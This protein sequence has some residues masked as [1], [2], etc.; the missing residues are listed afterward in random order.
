MTEDTDRVDLDALDVGEDEEEN[1]QPR[2]GEWFWNEES[3][4]EVAAESAEAGSSATDDEAGETGEVTTPGT[5]DTGATDESS[6]SDATANDDGRAR[7]PHVPRENKNQPVGIPVAEGGAGGAS[8]RAAAERE[9]DAEE[10][11]DGAPAEDG[12][13]RGGTVGTGDSGSPASEMTMAFSYD[14]M[15]RFASPVLVMAN[16]EEWTDWIG[17]VG[18]VDAY[19][20]NKYVREEGLDID[21]FNGAGD[22]PA[23]R[24]A[25]ITTNPNSMFAAE[26]TVLVGTEGDWEIADRADWEFVPLEAAADAAGWDLKD[27]AE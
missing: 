19:V 24:L 17:L 21:F 4:A 3:G 7:V 6:E 26:R 23:D 13:E 14:A 2:R 22:G 25:E 15:K 16:A 10:E 20:I 12:E 27:P 9:S 18:E 5:T 8:A 1:E 11:D